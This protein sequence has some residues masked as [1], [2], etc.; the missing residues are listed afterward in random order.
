MV[1]LNQDVAHLGESAMKNG[2]YYSEPLNKRE[3]QIL[4]LKVQRQSNQKLRNGYI[5]LSIP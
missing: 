5:C 2:F 3:L 1:N 4:R